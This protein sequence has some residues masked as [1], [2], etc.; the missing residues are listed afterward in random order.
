ML[1]YAQLYEDVYL[2]RCFGN[3]KSG[4]Y[5]DVGASHPVYS[6]SAHYFY[7]QGWSGVNIE[8][9]PQRHL[10][11]VHARPRDVNLR[12][13]VGSRAGRA[14]FYVSW[15]AD[16][17]SSLYEQD[18]G[19]IDRH[20]AYLDTI[21]VE[22]ITLSDIC[23]RYAKSQIDFIKID[24]EGAER[25]VIVGGDWDKWRPAVVL[26]EAVAPASAAPTWTAWEPNLL[27]ARYEFA[28]FDGVNRFYVA[29]ERAEL[30]SCFAVP[31]NP[32]DGAV[33]F[34][35]FGHVLHD[36]RHPD[37]AWARN[38]VDRVLASAAVESEETILRLMTWDLGQEQLLSVA[39]RADVSIAFQRVLARSPSELDF[40][41]W[42]GQPHLNLI[43]LYEELIRG[44]EFLFRR[45]RVSTLSIVA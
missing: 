1:S 7:E 45:S 28:F 16:H 44:E 33:Q 43:R 12:A 35:A 30:L 32:F 37:H 4:F 26:V 22:L 41:H 39:T 24:V 3:R 40:T 23:E 19:M 38:F 8:P 34:H 13:A 31:A 18:A 25:D 20:S 2:H 10:E 11:L 29:R 14:K 15:K 42:A 5:I 6:N 27:Q 36:R 9:I 17:L 21:E